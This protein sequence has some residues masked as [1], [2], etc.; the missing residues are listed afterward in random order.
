MQKSFAR[1]TKS[2]D[3]IFDFIGAFFRK[4]RVS[5]EVAFSVKFAIEELFTN[6]VKYNVSGKSDISLDI[7]VDGRNLVVRLTDFEAEPFD[8]TKAPDPDLHASLDQRR[9]GG[10]GIFLVKRMVDKIE[11]HHKDKMSII[12]LVQSLE[13]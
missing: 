1:S 12:T 9:A 10:L 3:E 7:S 8:P 2:L 5:K 4:H 13:K 6:F 11:Y